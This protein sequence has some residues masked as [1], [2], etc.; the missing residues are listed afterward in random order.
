MSEFGEIP[1]SNIHQPVK[2]APSDGEFYL[3]PGFYS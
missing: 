1:Q 3:F 2:E